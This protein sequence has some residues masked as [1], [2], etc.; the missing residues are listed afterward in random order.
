MIVPR[1]VNHQSA[2]Y[3]TAALQIANQ[4]HQYVLLKRSTLLGHIAPVF[5]ALKETTSAIQTDSKTTN[6]TR[7][8][9]R[10]ALTRAF[11]KTTFTPAACKKY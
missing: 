4:S 6:S 9:L 1:T 5:V 3:K 2:A 10:A 8:E 7:N 11:D